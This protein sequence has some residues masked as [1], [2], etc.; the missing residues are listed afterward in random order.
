MALPID[1]LF[2]RDTSAWICIIIRCLERKSKNIPH[3][4]V[5]NGDKSHGRIRKKSNSN[6]QVSRK[7][8]FLP[9]QHDADMGRG[10]MAMSLFRKVTFCRSA[11]PPSPT[12]ESQNL[13]P[14]KIW[15]LNLKG[16]RFGRRPP[17]KNLQF[18]RSWVSSRIFPT[19]CR[20][21]DFK[22]LKATMGRKNRVWCDML[23]LQLQNLSIK[24][25][26]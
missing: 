15:S 21:S 23:V 1:S 12:L 18:H 26:Y 11:I 14:S 20:G 16:T 8:R 9:P 6:K 22:L 19:I 5:K 4:V 2:S 17:K 24:N 13:R 7:V 25:R 10:H 3:M